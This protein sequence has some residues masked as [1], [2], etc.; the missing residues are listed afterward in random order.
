MGDTILCCKHCSTSV[1]SY[2]GHFDIL[3]T[4]TSTLHADDRIS[5]HIKV[6]FFLIMPFLFLL[7][8]NKYKFIFSLTYISYFFIL[9]HDWKDYLFIPNMQDLFSIRLISF[10]KN[11]VRL[12]SIENNLY[13][14][15]CTNCSKHLGWYLM[16]YLEEKKRFYADIK[17]KNRFST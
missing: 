4:N 6:S 11:N 12:G 1:A 13:D 7:Y 2:Q 14:V 17:I 3:N 10:I 16:S 9:Q 15:G 8:R 5:S